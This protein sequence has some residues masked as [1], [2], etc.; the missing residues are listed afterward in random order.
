MT[1]WRPDLSRHP[2]PSYQAL[3]DAIATAVR[4]GE[5]AHGEKLP[6]QRD[7]AAE[8]GLAVATVGRAYTIAEQRRLVSGQVGRGTFVLDPVDDALS[9]LQ[10][11]NGV[12]DLTR[13][14]PSAV[15]QIA[16]LGHTMEECSRSTSLREL[17]DYMPEFG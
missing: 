17:I 12:I 8:L 10:A 13:N 11:D 1:I 7:L 9:A 15:G 14:L 6:P 2:G 3:A 4:D 16:A 5:L